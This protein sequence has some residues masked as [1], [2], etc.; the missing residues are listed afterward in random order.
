M[1]KKIKTQKEII[2]L[3][4]DLKKQNKKIVT[5]NGVFDILHS[6]HIKS[7][8]EAKRQGDIL[9][10]LLNSDKSV[11]SYKGFQR[12]IN[13]E[14]D[15]AKVLSALTAVDYIVT[16]NELTPNKIL[17]KIKPDI[18]CVGADWGKGSI[19]EKIVKRQGGE[20]HVLK[21]KTGMSTSG[22]I[23]KISKLGQRPIVRA[24]FLDRDGVI[25][26]NEPEFTHQIKDF[27]F[28]PSVIEGL[29]RLSQTEFKII[30][31]TN[32]SGIAR[33]YFT[34]GDLKKLHHWM[35]EF[36]KNKGIRIDKIYYCPH[37]PDFGS[38]EYRKK[39]H[40]RKPN[41][42]MI[43]QTVKDFDISL[44][45][46]WLVSDDVRDILMGRKANLKTIFLG[47]DK[48]KNFNRLDVLPHHFAR[49]FL[50]VVSIILQKSGGSNHN[51]Y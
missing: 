1:N 21:Q 19:E 25:N 48:N 10:I 2:E 37:H 39:C 44:N 33:G 18:H 50:D 47:S 14:K 46:S 32:Q 42:G 5:Y 9:I 34:E 29:K 11:K 27:K 26:E 20:I 28:L 41:L 16:F 24:I 40:C 6:G 49:N 22:I 4:P 51:G 7:L 12:P 43:Q 17:S 8:Q 30:I 45:D 3:L 31:I 15:R 35:L 13:C 38:K 23:E 36:L